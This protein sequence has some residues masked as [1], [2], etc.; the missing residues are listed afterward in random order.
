MLKKFILYSIVILTVSCVTGPKIFQ[1]YE[2]AIEELANKIANQIEDNNYNRMDIYIKNG[3]ERKSAKT[4]E[5]ELSKE[6][7]SSLSGYLKRNRII[8][9]RN[10]TIFTEENS[11]QECEDVKKLIESNVLILILR[12]HFDDKKFYEINVEN[13]SIRN[14]NFQIAQSVYLNKNENISNSLESKKIKQ[15]YKEHKKSLYENYDEAAE[16]IVNKMVCVFKILINKNS[17][18]NFRVAIE[19]SN[20]TEIAIARAISHYSSKKGLVVIENRDNNRIL[21]NLLFNIDLIKSNHENIS[22]LSCR[23]KADSQIKIK[24]GK[25]QR[26]IEKNEILPFCSEEVLFKSDNSKINNYKKLFKKNNNIKLDFEVL[27]DYTVIN[28][29]KIQNNY[30]FRIEQVFIDNSIKILYPTDIVEG[31]LSN[32]KRT[33]KIYTVKKDNA[34]GSKIFVSVYPGEKYKEKGLVVYCAR[35]E[36]GLSF[37]EYQNLFKNNE[38]WEVFCE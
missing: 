12:E 34:I 16:K 10:I 2:N 38:K 15:E 25:E 22:K 9:K 20:T 26:T 1:I 31:I 8:K 30:N 32:N 21:P 37:E 7:I 36:K 33:K 6:I 29:S 14:I 35:E 11:S 18:S 23:L 17:I 28:Y 24:I 13:K 5:S 3:H 19:K 27:K 4:K